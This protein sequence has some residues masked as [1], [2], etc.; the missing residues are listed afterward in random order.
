MH[1]TTHLNYSYSY[2]SFLISLL[3]N[4][5]LGDISAR[6]F[7][8]YQLS[9]QFLNRLTQGFQSG[10][11]D[12]VH[13]EKGRHLNHLLKATNSFYSGLLD[14][15]SLLKSCIVCLQQENEKTHKWMLSK[16]AELMLANSQE[17]IMFLEFL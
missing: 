10:N 4:L 8:K 14:L 16:R 2:S 6:G 12:K 9:V 7:F 3:D 1:S 17:M 11:V 5:K 13:F 15:E